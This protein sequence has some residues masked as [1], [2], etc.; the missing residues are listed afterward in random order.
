MPRGPLAILAIAVLAPAARGQSSSACSA[1]HPAIWESYRRSGMAR[2]FFRPAA[3]NTIEDY[4]NA[5]TYDHFASDIHFEMI[6]RDG[7]Y[8]QRQYQIGFDRKQTNAAE[9]QIDFVLGSGNHARSYLHR[10]PRG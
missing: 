9:N 8:F 10:T 7:K 4:T 1:C 6:E 5:H 3:E 2:S